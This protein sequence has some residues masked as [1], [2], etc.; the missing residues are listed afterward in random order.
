MM[1]NYRYRRPHFANRLRLDKLMV[2]LIDYNNN[3]KIIV[4]DYYQS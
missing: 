3:K 2:Y 4:I 1:I